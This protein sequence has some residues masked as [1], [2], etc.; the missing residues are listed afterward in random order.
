M[1]KGFKLLLPEGL[2]HAKKCVSS[3][4]VVL[5][6]YLRSITAIMQKETGKDPEIAFKRL[7]ALLVTQSERCK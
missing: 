4:S 1:H 5:G 7:G 6:M 2:R 3:S